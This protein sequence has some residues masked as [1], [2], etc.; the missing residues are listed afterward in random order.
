MVR[1]FSVDSPADLVA[2]NGLASQG[3]CSNVAKVWSATRHSGNT[4]WD[5][6]FF[7]TFNAG[8]SGPKTASV[9]RIGLDEEIHEIAKLQYNKALQWCSMYLKP[10]VL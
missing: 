10:L 7:V 3:S 5:N 4:A 1:R 8:R 9:I 6:R 2:L